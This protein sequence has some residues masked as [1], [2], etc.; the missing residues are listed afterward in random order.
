MRPIIAILILV[1]PCGVAAS[2]VYRTPLSEAGQ[3]GICL[4]GDRLF[5]TVHSRL[6]GPMNGGFY[7]SGSIEGQ[8][9][10]KTS[11][12]LL[13]TGQSVYRGHGG[14]KF[15]NHGMTQPVFFRSRMN[16]TS[17]STT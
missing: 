14:E 8:C 10:D 9:F 17:F 13:W 16:R 1:S 2:S 5:L 12:K 3:S 6:Q 11:G 7:F 4:Y 15:S